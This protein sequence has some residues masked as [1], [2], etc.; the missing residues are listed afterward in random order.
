MS[1]ATGSR[2]ILRAIATRARPRGTAPSTRCPRSCSS[3]SSSWRSSS[4]SSAVLCERRGLCRDRIELRPPIGVRR[5][6][7]RENQAAQ[8]VQRTHVHPALEID[9]FAHRCPIVDP[10]PTIELRLAGA[11]KPQLGFL[12]GEPQEEPALLLTDAAVAYVLA[13]QPITQP[14]AGR[15]QYLDV[16]AC[17]AD[18][19]LQFAEERIFH[20][21]SAV[22]ASLWKLPAAAADSPPQEQ[23]PGAAHQH[24]SHIRAEPVPIDGIAGSHNGHDA[25]V[26][27]HRPLVVIPI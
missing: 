22:N 4:R 26:P 16:L 1:I 3:A 25:I 15:A 12:G 27:Y 6:T 18:L 9:H 21:L 10:A 8:I 11:V 2:V 20:P 14:S 24:D 23:L 5:Q 19:L 7:I 13:R 17:E